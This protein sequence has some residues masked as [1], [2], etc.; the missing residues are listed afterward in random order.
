MDLL[1]GE[2]LDRRSVPLAATD[3]IEEPRAL[4]RVGGSS[5]CTIAGAAF[6]TSQRILDAEQRLLTADGRR[7]GSAVDQVAVDLALLEMAANGS[8]SMPGRR[9][10]SG[11]C[12]RRGSYAAR[13]RSRRLAKPLRLGFRSRGGARRDHDR[14]TGSWSPN[15]T[16]VPGRIVLITPLPDRRCRWPTATRPAS[17]M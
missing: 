15:S 17:E 16:A 4:R 10:W 13:G 8:P 2:V 9:P 7:D 3:D 14:P 11:R 6:Y 1:V 5:V 12:A